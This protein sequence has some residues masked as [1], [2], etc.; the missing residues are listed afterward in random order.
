MRS[1]FIRQTAIIYRPM[2]RIFGANP[3]PRIL[4]EQVP[5]E[6]HDA[7]RKSF[8]TVIAVTLR[9]EV[10][11]AEFDVLVTAVSP[12]GAERHLFVLVFNEPNPYR[13]ILEQVTADQTSFPIK[14][15]APSK[16][17]EFHVPTSIDPALQ[18]F[19]QARVIP[20]LNR[21][22]ENWVLGGPI[23][24][25]K[26]V[27]PFI[28]TFR[29]ETLAGRFRRMSGTEC[30]AFPFEVVEHAV[31][32]LG[33][34]IELWRMQDLTRFPFPVEDWASNPRWLTSPEEEI[35]REL[36][37][38]RQ[39]RKQ[40]LAELDS[41]ESVLET[42]FGDA[43]TRADADER[44]LLTAQGDSLV[45]A[46]E[47]CFKEFGFHVKYMDAI[48]KVGDR[49]EDL[50]V[51]LACDAAWTNITE[52]RGYTRGA[53]LNDLL[54]IGR[55]RTRYMKDEGKVP[56]SAWYVANEL[57]ATDP[58]SRPLVLGANNTEVE[59][60][61]E[62][63]GLAIATVTLF[64]MLMDLRRELL[65]QDDAQ[66]LLRESRGRLVYERRNAS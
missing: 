61:G 26:V 66:R 22:A 1:A 48:W 13:T 11:Q 4:L 35:T 10:D 63:D 37:G 12:E 20:V 46:V 14:W 56:S 36:H 6:L 57:I 31:E 52:V 49:R 50:R 41:Q 62:D 34:A 60:F 59:T 54:R 3:R 45:R 17:H 27:T 8:P 2:S 9:D 24:A 30:W 43:R 15:L 38:L 25:P 58:G 47:R 21:K 28:T 5:E 16:G 23:Q 44:Q 64:D 18:R 7:F 33:I 39:Q 40:V 65:S 55:F 29:G 19:V 53:E 42:K 32:C 51:S